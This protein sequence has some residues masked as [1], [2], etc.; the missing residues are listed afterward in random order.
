MKPYP[1]GCHGPKMQRRI[2]AQ[3]ATGSASS[4]AMIPGHRDPALV[5]LG[6]PR[7]RVHTE[8]FD[9]V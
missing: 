2:Q 4:T 5:G 3:A 8:R 9:M 7:E 6:V 1:R